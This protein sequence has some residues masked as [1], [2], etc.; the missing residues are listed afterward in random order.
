M[1]EAL[2]N[3]PH[4]LIDASLPYY[5]EIF[6]SDFTISIFCSPEE[7]QH[8]LYKQPNLYNGII[9]RSTLTINR[10]HF[11]LPSSI[12]FIATA[13]SGIDH[14]DRNYL[15]SKQISLFDAKGSNANAVA[16]YVFSVLAYFESYLGTTRPDL[17]ELRTIGI[18]GYGAVGQCVAKRL[19]SLNKTI[20][21][22]DPWLAE[23]S[24][25]TL[26]DI[27][28]CDAISIHANLHDNE[29]YPSRHLINLA[30]LKKLK[31]G[32]LVI[33]AARGGL[34]DERALLKLKQKIYY[35]TDV[36]D[37]EPHINPNIIQMA[38]LCTPHI[39]GHSI[40]AKINAVVLLAKQIY[41]YYSLPVPSDYL[42]NICNFY[43]PYAINSNNWQ[44]EFLEFYNPIN[45]TNILKKSQNLAND[46]LELRSQHKNRHDVAW[47]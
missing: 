35:C 45:E 40:E 28:S 34:V 6:Y 26:N 25:N 5:N 44:N 32:A 14:I 9:C 37:N 39:A 10:S 19:H 8:K 47:I 22:Y 23:Y 30:T 29:P 4:L 24:N 18:I 33:N 15:V 38:T 43:K 3:M 7:L 36:Y 17:F 42:K 1:M 2:N 20:K 21:I 16:D 12:Q 11:D 41:R 31:P 13:S 27:L 46:F